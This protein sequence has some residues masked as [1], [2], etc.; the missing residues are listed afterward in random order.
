ML[1]LSEAEDATSELQAERHCGS[2]G[3]LQRFPKVLWE[4]ELTTMLAHVDGLYLG[5]LRFRGEK[6]T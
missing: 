1:R 3:E 4:A 6:S 5:E 2:I